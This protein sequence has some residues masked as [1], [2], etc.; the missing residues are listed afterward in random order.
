[1]H[2]P[3]P[4]GRRAFS[5]LPCASGEFERPSPLTSF[6]K[7]RHQRKGK[8]NPPLLHF[9]LPPFPCVESCFIIFFM[10]SNCLISRFTSWMEVP[11]P[12]AIRRRRLALRIS[13][14]C[15]S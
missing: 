2:P 13:G 11:L 1:G 6:T 12:R 10:F 7:S 3:P 5:W 8:G 15:F 14:C 4:P 9:F